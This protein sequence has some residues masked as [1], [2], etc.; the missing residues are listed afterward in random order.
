MRSAF[1]I[2]RHGVPTRKESEVRIKKGR[3]IKPTA[4]EY[5]LL[6][7]SS[8]I[9]VASSRTATSFA[10]SGARNLKS[11]ANLR[12]YVTHLHQKIESDP[13]SPSLIKTEPGIGYRF[14]SNEAF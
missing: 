6:R 4:T 5:A 13:A 12:V 10:K 8:G 11:T 1:A 14:I 3:E 2:F 9:L 7:L